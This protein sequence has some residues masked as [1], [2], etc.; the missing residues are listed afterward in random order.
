[1]LFHRFND[2]KEKMLEKHKWGYFIDIEDE[3]TIL[4]PAR[5]LYITPVNI[6]NGTKCQI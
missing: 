4:M 6:M 3:N 1:M 2:K 5:D